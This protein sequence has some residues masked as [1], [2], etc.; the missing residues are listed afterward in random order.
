MRSIGKELSSLAP[1]ELVRY[2]P[3]LQGN[4]N[5]P[6]CFGTRM[7]F[8][9]SQVTLLKSRHDADTQCEID[10][11]DEDE[12]IMKAI[13][14]DDE[15]GC[16]PT[17][18]MGLSNYSS[19]YP[20]CNTDSQYKRIAVLTTNFTSLENVRDQIVPPCQEM[21]IVTNVQMVKGRLRKGEDLYL[22][23]QFRHVNDRYQ[24][25]TNT[26]GFSVES[27]WSGI[28]GFIG[29]FVG[30]SLMQLPEIFLAFYTFLCRR[31]NKSEDKE[32]MGS[33]FKV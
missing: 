12:K 23:I 21:I 9:I 7:T 31:S 5:S 32:K 15:V 22:D 4:W 20:K 28:G 33:K 13:L 17:F 29:I 27:C 26:R 2:C 25:I 24:V 18:W 1:G 14:E 11:K 6:D 8:D 16:V 19:R 30:V 3:E 10:L